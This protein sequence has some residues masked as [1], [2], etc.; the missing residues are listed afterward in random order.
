MKVEKEMSVKNFYS[1]LSGFL[2]HIG[3]PFDLRLK[4]LE[5]DIESDYFTL[6]DA[7]LGLMIINKEFTQNNPINLVRDKSLISLFEEE[8]KNT[9]VIIYNGF[10]DSRNDRDFIIARFNFNVFTHFSFKH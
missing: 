3:T 5:R 1:S 2:G 9:A 10:P 8:L 4:D 7:K 6:E